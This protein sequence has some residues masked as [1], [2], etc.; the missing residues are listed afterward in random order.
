M[1]AFDLRP[2]PHKLGLLIDQ[3]TC[4]L[5]ERAL[6]LKDGTAEEAEFFSDWPVPIEAVWQGL[7]RGGLYNGRYAKELDLTSDEVAFGKGM[8][9]AILFKDEDGVIWVEYYESPE[10]L[11]EA[12]DDLRSGG[13]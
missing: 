1:L 6:S 13:W 9:G 3:Y 11:E 7:L 5:F 2:H 12:W 4:Y 8:A 10:E